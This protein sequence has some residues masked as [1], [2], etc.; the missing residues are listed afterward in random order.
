MVSIEELLER[1]QQ[2][3]TEADRQ[4]ILLEM[5]MSQ[6]PDDLVSVLWAAAV[7]HFFDAE[8]LA[9]LRPKLAD[10]SERLYADLQRLTFVEEFVGQGQNVHE[11]TRDVL[12]ARLWSQRR[13]EF[14]GLSKRAADYFFEVGKSLEE[15]VEFCYHDILN[16][17]GSQTGRLLNRVVDW[18]TYNQLDRIQATLQGFEEHKQ[19]S[20]L[21]AF[22]LGFLLHLKGLSEMR[23]ADY[24]QAEQFFE[25]AQAIYD[26][27]EI[28]NPRYLTT[29]LRDTSSSKQYQGRYKDAVPICEKALRISR[30]QLGDRR[31]D[32]ASSL[33][34]LAGLYGSQGRYGEAEPL[35]VQALEICKVKLGDRHPDTAASLNNL[36]GLYE[37]QGRYGEAEP[38]YLKALEIKKA[39]LGDRHPATATSLNNLAW[40]Y[41]SQERY[42]EAEPLYLEALEIRKAELGDRHPDT[43]ASLNNLAE[44]YKVTNE[45]KKS[46]PLLEEWRIV[47]RSRQE[48]QTQY[49]AGRTRTLGKI[50]EQCNQLPEAIAAYEEALSLFNKLLGFKDKRSLMMKAELARLKKRVKR[51]SKSRE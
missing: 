14:L 41:E 28:K 23:A 15:E 17:G 45:Y 8:V 33:N 4:W 29:L 48:D 51:N 13:D 36:A 1:V 12:L 46:I 47:Q 50:Y 18:W 49:F 16:E 39:E 19:A 38:L 20:R 43:A 35:Y 25:Q 34:N 26:E 30:E 32:T 37:S 5:Q 22:A 11:L 44:F 6:M 9:A 2:A 7:P 10:E 31:P 21:E 42:G 40:L 27:I 3:E 24:R